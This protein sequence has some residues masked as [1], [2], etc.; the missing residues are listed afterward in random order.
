MT[1]TYGDIKIGDLIDAELVTN[2]E[3]WS[4]GP[5][6]GPS[7]TFVRI[8]A[9]SGGRRT[10]KASYPAGPTDWRLANVNDVDLAAAADVF[11]DH[12][13]DRIVP[14]T[15]ALEAL[16]GVAVEINRRAA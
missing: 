2:V 9:K 3:T 1:Y 12:F 4:V 11:A 8:T 15:W 14:G 16:H 6:D 10:E 13:R 5:V 7:E